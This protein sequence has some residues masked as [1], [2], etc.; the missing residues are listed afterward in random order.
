MI[1]IILPISRRDYLRPVFECLKNLEKPDDTELL[2][3]IDGDKALEKAVDKRLDSLKFEKIQVI[4]FGDS[5]AED[6]NSRRFRISAIHN[7]AKHYIP[8]ECEY[9]FLVEDDTVYPKHTLTALLKTFDRSA[10]AYVG[11]IQLGR[12]NS[13]Y[14]GAWVTEN[15]DNPILIESVEPSQGLEPVDASGFYCCLIDAGLYKNHHF[16][17][18]DKK[19]TNGLS[20]DVN[21]GFYLRRQGYNVYVNHDIQCDHIGD[22]GSVNLGNT[23]PCKLQFKKENNKWSCTRI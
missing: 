11:A 14:L 19:G 7:K 6:I 20:C 3:V 9:V 17:P 22:R 12:H 5:P 1:T 2:I 18:L 8:E 21:F 15:V 10:T 4:N 13:P 16:E 23:T